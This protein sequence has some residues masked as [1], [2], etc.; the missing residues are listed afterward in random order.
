MSGY[1]RNLM[2]ILGFLAVLGAAPAH[3][4]ESLDSGKTAAQL[5]GSD[6]AICHKTPQGL[7]KP[8]RISGLDN[9]LRQHYTASRE[10]AAALAAYLQSVAKGSAAPAPERAAKRTGKGDNNAKGVE[11]KPEMAKS[12]D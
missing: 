3:A 6:C 5:F 9:F 4:Q 11:K 8:G 2:C 1:G 10:S 12:G 7:A